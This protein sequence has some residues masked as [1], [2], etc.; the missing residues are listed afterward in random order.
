M[1]NH[2]GKAGRQSRTSSS[3][4][5]AIS[6]AQFQREPSTNLSHSGDSYSNTYFE[7]SKEQPSPQNPLGNMAWGYPTFVQRTRWPVDLTTKHNDSFIRTFNFAR[8]GSVVDRN[9][10]DLEG[11]PG[12]SI[13]QQLELMFLPS[14]VDFDMKVSDW[15]KTPETSLFV[16]FIG[17]NDNIKINEGGRAKDKG[18]Q[19]LLLER[20][21]EFM[22]R[23]CGVFGKLYPI[24]TDTAQSSTMPA[25]ATS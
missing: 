24:H 18:L 3:C 17:I 9:P 25:R 8:S 5:P 13:I 2:H 11:P 1:K 19:P 21:E 20:Y 22:H 12:V 10:V 14:Y 7:P 4:A 6:L 15:K 16:V 23:V